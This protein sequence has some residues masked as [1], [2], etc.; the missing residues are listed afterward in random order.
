MPTATRRQVHAHARSRNGNPAEVTVEITSDEASL[1]PDAMEVE[2]EHDIEDEGH[3]GVDEDDE[4]AAGRAS[5][6]ASQ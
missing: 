4:E 5:V 6:I 1:Q 3:D 2:P